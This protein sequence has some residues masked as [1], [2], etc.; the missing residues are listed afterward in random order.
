IPAI[1]A[2]IAGVVALGMSWDWRDLID[3]RWEGNRL[4]AAWIGT[5]VGVGALLSA[6]WTV[7]FLLRRAYL[8]DMGWEKLH[9]YAELSFP[10]RIAAVA[11]L[12]AQT[13]DAPHRLTVIGGT[14]L[15]A[16]I[17]FWAVALPLR[18]LPLG[19][20]AADGVTYSW[21]RPFNIV[22]TKDKHFIHDWA[23]WNYSG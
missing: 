5:V 19:H 6:F 21:P 22:K 3:N 14:V 1:F 15:A 12:V 18:V 23:T 8:T 9:N 17:A 20:T 13:D 2:V 4:R 10:G 16:L 7:P 11:V